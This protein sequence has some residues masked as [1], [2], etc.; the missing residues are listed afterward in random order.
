MRSSSIYRDG[1][2]VLPYGEPPD[3]WL[4]LDLRRV[5]SPT[6]RLSNSWIG[7]YLLIGRDTNP[8]LVDRTNREGIVD[9]PALEDLRNAVRQLLVMLETER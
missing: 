5:Q 6:R 3:G 2:R 7:G 8:E 9:G 4:R 1:L